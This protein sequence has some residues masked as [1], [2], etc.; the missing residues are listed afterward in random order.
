MWDG[1]R[2][3]DLFARFLEGR[4][5]LCTK[6]PLARD[7]GAGPLLSTGRLARYAGGVYIIS[8]L[9]QNTYSGPQAAR[10][11]YWRPAAKV[12]DGRPTVSPAG[13]RARIGT[14]PCAGPCSGDGGFDP[15][16]EARFGNDRSL[17][18]TLPC[19]ASMNCRSAG[20]GTGECVARPGQCSS[21]PPGFPGRG[22]AAVRAFPRARPAPAAPEPA[23]SRHRRTAPLPRIRHH[24]G[25]RSERSERPCDGRRTAYGD[26]SDCK[27]S[28]VSPSSCCGREYQ[29]SYFL[30]S[31]DEANMDKSSGKCESGINPLCKKI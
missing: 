30:S 19:G 31:I 25:P 29:T 5:F 9:W 10:P 28:C 14:E 2:P 7:P 18:G 26:P 15:W 24:S 3:S 17:V 1:H 6:L 13:D 8:A 21:E 4:C 12:G 20:P 11:G 22:V 27:Y 16:F 23:R